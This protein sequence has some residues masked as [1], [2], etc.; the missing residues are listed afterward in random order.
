MPYRL[1]ARLHTA[2]IA[3]WPSDRERGQ[4][5]VEYVALILLLALV[6]AAVVKFGAG[7]DFDIGKTIVDKLKDAI[8]GVGD[9]PKKGG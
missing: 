4:G 5:T 2:L 9:A 1:F 7:K 3:A 6:F 8:D